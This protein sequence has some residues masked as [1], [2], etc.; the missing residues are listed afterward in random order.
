MSSTWF[1]ACRGGGAASP[2]RRSRPPRR[3]PRARIMAARCVLKYGRP[4]KRP[5]RH[6][7]YGMPTWRGPSPSRIGRRAG[8]PCTRPTKTPRGAA[9]PG[10][11]WKSRW[12]APCATNPSISN[13]AR[14]TWRKSGPSE[15]RRQT[16]Q[17][18]ALGVR[19]GAP[20][21]SGF[22]PRVGDAR[23]RRA[24]ALAVDRAAIHNVLLQRQ[25]E[26]SARCCRSGSR[27]TLFYFPPRPMPPGRARW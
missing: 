15:L 2:W 9:V 24:L 5:T 1:A 18:Q 7:R 21:G 22:S 25:G 23:V 11:R 27:A 26:V 4:S 16:S 10:H 8:A 20:G 14:R 12:R 13:S 6:R 19:A 3:P 17:A